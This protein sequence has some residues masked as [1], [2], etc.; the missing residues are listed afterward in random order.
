MQANLMAYADEL[1]DEIYVCP[2]FGDWKPSV[3]ESMCRYPFKA[4]YSIRSC[5]F[6]PYLLLS[7]VTR[8]LRLPGARYPPII[9]KLVTGLLRRTVV[10]PPRLRPPHSPPARTH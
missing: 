5:D 6:W 10:T 8:P 9:R 7:D 2:I 3:R 4:A 1:Y